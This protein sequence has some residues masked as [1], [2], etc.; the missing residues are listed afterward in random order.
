MTTAQR[1]DRVLANAV[2]SDLSSC[3]QV[4]PPPSARF[5]VVIA[6]GTLFQAVDVYTQT[7]REA[8]EWAADLRDPD[9]EVDVMRIA[10]DG[11]LTT[12]F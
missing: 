8:E 11:S 9:T 1:V 4:K 12:E 10:S 2:G 3:R 7:L 6:P 5:A